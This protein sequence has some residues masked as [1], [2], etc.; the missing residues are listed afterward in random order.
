MGLKMVPWVISVFCVWSEMFLHQIY[1]ISPWKNCRES[2]WY[3]LQSMHTS[4]TVMNHLLSLLRIVC[5]CVFSWVCVHLSWGVYSWG[6]DMLCFWSQ[7]LNS[8]SK[9]LKRWSQ[10]G[11]HT[12]RNNQPLSTLYGQSLSFAKSCHLWAVCWEQNYT[13]I[14]L[15]LCMD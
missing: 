12:C 6:T 9:K 14:K 4:W 10:S 8:R 11:A 5:V 1:L 3:C 2:F 15:S 13:L 7:S